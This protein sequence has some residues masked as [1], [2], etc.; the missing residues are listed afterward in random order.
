ME[1]PPKPRPRAQDIDRHIGARPRQRRVMTGLFQRRMAELIGAWTPVR[2]AVPR[3]SSVSFSILRATSG[4]FGHASARKRSACW[5]L[6]WLMSRPRRKSMQ[7]G[8]PCL[9]W[10]KAPDISLVEGRRQPIRLPSKPQVRAPKPRS[11]HDSR[12]MVTGAV[13]DIG[14]RLLVRLYPSTLAAAASRGSIT[15]SVVSPAM[16]HV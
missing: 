4:A 12:E 2:K 15:L 14:R 13:R 1:R 8:T 11:I 10:T 3:R 7:L 5:R 9:N 16:A 6:F